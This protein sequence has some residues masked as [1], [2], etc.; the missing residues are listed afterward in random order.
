MPHAPDTKQNPTSVSGDGIASSQ[1]W[2][3]HR[4]N[5]D[6]AE[7]LPSTATKA[8]GMNMYGYD[9]AIIEV[10][11]SGTANPTITVLFW[12]ERASAYVREHTNLQF[13]GVGADVPFHVRVPCRG[14]RMFV[15]VTT[16]AGGAVDI[17]VAGARTLIQPVAS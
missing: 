16:L 5:V 14:R 2:N 10:L 17:A 15:A 4:Q 1:E 8:Q 12:S 11:P 13:A 9:D 3:L 6:A 7:S